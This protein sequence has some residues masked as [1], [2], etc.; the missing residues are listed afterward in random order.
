MRRRSTS[1]RPKPEP[2]VALINIVFL[3]LVFFLVAAQLARPLE[4]DLRL[5]E[6]DDPKLV[7]PPDAVTL[8]PDGRTLFRGAEADATQVLTALRADGLPLVGKILPDQ[9]APA[10]DLIQLAQ[11]LRSAGATKVM[12]MTRQA[13]K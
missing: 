5:V 10:T 1:P 13:L 2:T 4:Q 7:P 8:F 3:M 12:I 9:A 6:T 11:A